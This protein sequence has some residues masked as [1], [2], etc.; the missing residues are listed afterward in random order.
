MN[1]GQFSRHVDSTSMS[2]K[3]ALRVR[4]LV[5][6]TGIVVGDGAVAG[7]LVFLLLSFGEYQVWGV[8][9]RRGTTAS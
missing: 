8:L 7:D 2:L 3:V 6:A 9:R 5:K 4:S 1:G